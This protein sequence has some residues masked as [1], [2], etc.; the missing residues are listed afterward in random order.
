MRKLCVVLFWISLGV[1]LFLVAK[2]FFVDY[3]GSNR[4]FV[5]A[6]LVSGLVD[7]IY[8]AIGGCAVSVF[9]WG[10]LAPEESIGPPIDDD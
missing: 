1:I 2:I 3:I 10:W 6:I 5:E 4:S 7:W 8:T 9:F